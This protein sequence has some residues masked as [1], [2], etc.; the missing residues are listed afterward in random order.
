MENEKNYIINTTLGIYNFIKNL[1]DLPVITQEDLKKD[2]IL[3]ESQKKFESIKLMAQENIFYGEE[4]VKLD[5][6]FSK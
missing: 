6:F 5:R 3:L 2:N 4:F 1:L